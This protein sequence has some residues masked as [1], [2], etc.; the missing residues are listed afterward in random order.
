VVE[1]VIIQQVQ[2]GEEEGGMVQR[3]VTVE[4]EL[5]I[6]EVGAEAELGLILTAVKVVLV[7]L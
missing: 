2:G 1:E 7:L 5:I 3:V 4:K 6:Q